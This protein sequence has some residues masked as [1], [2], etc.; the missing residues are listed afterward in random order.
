[1]SGETQ[2]IVMH[3]EGVAAATPSSLAVVTLTQRADP[4]GRDR[5][6]LV[7]VL[8]QIERQIHCLHRG[9]H[10][11][12]PLFAFHDGDAQVRVHER[13]VDRPRVG[14][15][16][17]HPDDE[18]LR[19]VSAQCQMQNLSCKKLVISPATTHV[20]L[21]TVPAKAHSMSQPRLHEYCPMTTADT[22]AQIKG[23]IQ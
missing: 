23:C 7:Q 22:G 16:P 4:L 2:S 8:L 11:T 13:D 21:L 19:Q 15:Y 20:P 10:A 6:V 17:S 3:R 18:E 9:C 1:V 14:P 12:E 5:K